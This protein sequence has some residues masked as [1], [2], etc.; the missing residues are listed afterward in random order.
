MHQGGDVLEAARSVLLFDPE[1]YALVALV[2][3]FLAK[4][5]RSKD[6]RR[7][8][9]SFLHPRGIKEMAASKSHRIAYAVIDLLDTLEEGRAD[10]R[11]VALRAL[12][13]E[14]LHNSSLHLRRNTARVLLQIMKQIVREHGNPH[15]QVQ[16]AHDFLVASGGRPSVIRREL[17]AYHL[18]EMPEA[19]NQVAFD[20][21][22][23]DANTKGRKSPTHLIMD[24][25][26]KGIRDLTVIYYNFVRREAVAE[27]TE[28]AEIMGVTVRIGIE[29]SARFRGKYV[30]FIWAPR[31][32]LD[33]QHFLDFLDEPQV[34]AFLAEGREGSNYRKAY[35]LGLLQ[36]FNA[37]HLGA[38]N[39][40][41]GLDVP[42]L[43]EPTF[44]E[45]VGVGQPAVVHLAEYIHHLALPGM[46][47]RVEQLRA[48][49]ATA[50]IAEQEAMRKQVAELNGLLPHTIVERYLRP[51]LNPALGDPKI[52]VDG[53]GVPTL[54]T[55]GPRQLLDRLDTLRTGYRLTLNPSKLS[56]ADVLELLHECRGAITHLEIFN[57]KDY[58]QG[59]NPYA[60]RIAALRQTL[61]SSN[62]IAFKRII[63]EIRKDIEAA[64]EPDKA[65]RLEKI[66]EILGNLP[67]FLRWY[68]LTRLKS[69]IGSDSIG[70][71]RALYGMGLVVKDTLPRRAQKEI[72]REPRSRETIPVRTV[73]LRHTVWSPRV[74]VEQWLDRLYRLL[75]RI[76][77]LSTF[78][79]SRTDSFVVQE[80]ATR[81]DPQGNIATL[82]GLEEN[83]DNGLRLETD[84]GIAAA[85]KLRCRYL[86]TYWTNAFKVALG[87]APAFLTF[88]L[89]KD[90]WFLACFG[91][92]IWFAITGLRNILQSV[93]GGG[94]L[95]RSSM[96]KWNDL[97]SWQRVA[98]SLLYTGFS[99]PLLDYLVKM[100][101]L[102][103]GFGINTTSSPTLLYTVMAL[104]NGTYLASHSS[105]RGL[106][107][108]AVFGNFFRSVLSIPLAIGFNAALAQVL[109][110]SG[111]SAL[112]ANQALQLWA[113]VIAK[114][115][116]DVVAGLIEGAADRSTNMRLRRNDYQ[117][118][119]AQ[120]FDVHG[121]LEALF[122]DQNVS[123]MLETP[124]KLIQAVEKEAREL[125]AKLIINAL[126]LMYFWH[127]QPR[128]R[129]TFQNLLATST[130]EERQIILRTQR[131]LTRRRKVSE[132]LLNNLVGKNF[133]PPLAFYLDKS[134]RYLEELRRLEG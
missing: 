82:G 19:W 22:V 96:L 121:L 77:G 16:L 72:E 93:V 37:R 48:R 1:D 15:R 88:A 27:L 18:L 113:A 122:P 76:L 2:N 17:K 55:L 127:Y 126:D 133:G 132:I 86:S 49:F 83:P 63:Q 43:T 101:I 110:A 32:F 56:H 106:P 98:D 108:G 10:E 70:R 25:W 91:A 47:A 131:I 71:S 118:K 3:D 124:K 90:W 129:T 57:L 9:D 46:L 100:V 36:S 13:D 4:G 105:L 54:L 30:Q 26:I 29:L 65:D 117:G 102:D 130:V 44:L 68:R 81:A 125:E 116:S 103:R 95:V 51:S 7:L 92:V 123:E 50:D 79:L 41:Y 59:Q 39:Q 53:A 89:T 21:H 111:L 104:V 75:R 112:E 35:V 84:G 64:D 62:P 114:A 11:L 69:R 6:L 107:T 61:N 97:V 80:N 28:A 33:R 66:R 42:S 109:Q 128:A 60:D 119:L 24:A 34:Q 78:G 58:K 85:P 20:H 67:E 12:R 52:P 73:A 74:G 31:G 94:G 14:I 87:F 120:L 23:H 8:F 38:M 5:R 40:A 134:E 45:F 115:A 99:V